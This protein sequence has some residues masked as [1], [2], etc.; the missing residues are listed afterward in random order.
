MVHD[1]TQ[2]EEIKAKQ[3]TSKR[4]NKDI[5]PL[6]QPII[7]EIHRRLGLDYFGIDCHIDNEMNLL[8]FEINANMNVFTTMQTS[9]FKKHAEKTLQA[10]IKM[11]MKGKD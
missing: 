6:I 3:A 11:L 8:V 5:K 10:L 7:T 9:V 4:F 2:L 1:K